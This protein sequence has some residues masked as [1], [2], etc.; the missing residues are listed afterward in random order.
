MRDTPADSP[1]KE[2]ALNTY[3]L[4]IFGDL[5]GDIMLR[6]ADPTPVFGQAQR[7]MEDGCLELGGGSAITACQAARLGLRT[8]FVGKVGDDFQGRLL[9]DILEHHGVDAR[10]VIVDGRVKTGF[11]VHLCGED[12][13]A[14]LTYAGSLAALRADEAPLDLI[15]QGRHFHVS[16][17]FLQPALHAGLASLFREVKGAGI[18][19]SIDPA[20]DPTGTWNGNLHKV[21]SL[22]DIFLPNEQ[23]LCHIAG[24]DDV[25]EALRALWQ[26]IP[27]VAAKMGSR[28]AV[29]I[30][31]GELYT[32]PA[33]PV[34]AVDGTGAGE[35]FNAG[36][37]YGY[38]KGL[39]M[40]E[41]L[42]IA[43]ICGAVSTRALGGIQ[44]Q[45]SLTALED[46]LG[47]D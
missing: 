22:L 10:G 16:D 28:G 1:R 29:A 8:A 2:G 37:L 42:R 30:Q 33:H 40:Q 47:S 6:D 17:F 18:S 3:D 44:A 7:F 15:R 20:W 36:F 45:I 11:T 27:I 32:Q 4:V 26:G 39:P 9:I 31:D 19:T 35:N 5:N 25:T 43:C 38:L 23:E 41:C 12:D 13:R 14:M 46:I 24:R 34:D 21:L